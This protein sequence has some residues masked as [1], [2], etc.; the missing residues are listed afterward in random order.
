MKRGMLFVLVGIMALFP[1]QSAAAH[2]VN[3]SYTLTP[4]VG[5]RIDLQALAEDG[6][7]L[8]GETVEVYAPDQ[9]DAPWQTGEL[10]AEGRFA[11]VP[12]VTRSGTWEVRVGQDDRRAW[13][14]FPLRFEAGKAHVAL[15]DGVDMAAQGIQITY[16]VA[17]IATVEVAL[18][19]AFESG[20]VMS[21]AQVT[22]YAPD[23]PKHPWLTGLCDEDGRFAFTAD[24]D[25]PGTW[26]IQ[27]RKAGHGEWLK[28][29]LD[30]NT[31][32]VVDLGAATPDEEAQE[33][34]IAAGAVRGG[35]TGFSAGQIVLMA[36]S[37]I[38]G[39]VGTAL[40]FSRRRTGDRAGGK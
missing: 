12:D 16:A 8:A 14:R 25:R 38:W 31:V 18:E 27:V 33:L 32:E 7:P 2:G 37:V 36:G 5:L 29:A 11:L 24:L 20:E 23:D 22:V 6:E 19:A 26:E 4:V 40:Y 34:Q 30:A 10:S 17:E 35:D 15:A 3:L 39:L 28:I 13:L 9:P 21:E 1:I